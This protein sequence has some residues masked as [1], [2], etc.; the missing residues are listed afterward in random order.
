MRGVSRLLALGLRLDRL[1][2]TGAI[3]GYATFARLTGVRMAELCAIEVP[4]IDLEACRIRINDGKGGKD[5]V[6]LFGKSFATA[7]R[8][9][10]AAHPKYRWLFQN[11]LAGPF[12]TRRVEQIV[13]RYAEA[14]G[15]KATP[16]APARPRLLP[17]GRLRHCGNYPPVLK[18]SGLYFSQAIIWVKEHPVLTRKDFMGNHEWCFQQIAFADLKD[19][20]GFVIHGLKE[21]GRAPLRSAWRDWGGETALVLLLERMAQGEAARLQMNRSGRVFRGVGF[22]AEIQ[23]LF[24][25]QFSQDRPDAVTGRDWLAERRLLL[26]EQL[27]Y[28]PRTWPGSAAARL[29]IYGLSAG[30]DFR[31]AGYRVTGTE[32]VGEKLIYPHYMLMS[33]TPRPPGE[34][35]QVLRVMETNG[36]LPP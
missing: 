7:L 2:R 17:V 3:A 16:R 1:P 4:D 9:Y 35:Y 30:E 29:G 22:I 31:G 26:E 19:P 6:V 20:E 5:R 27:H 36:L 23:S 28:F 12:T 33:A 24:Y 15:V 10:L 8:A 13:K 21:D 32:C 34:V 25:P 18:A 14:A 11:R